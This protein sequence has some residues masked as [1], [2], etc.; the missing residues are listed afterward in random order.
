MP[1]RVALVTTSW[2]AHEQDPA[3]HFVRAEARA[4]ERTG[5]EVVVLAPPAGGAFGWPGVAARIREKPWRALYAARW[6]T[7]ATQRVRNL[8]VD[9][10]V[11]HWALPSAWPIGHGARAPIE[12][13]SHGGDVRLLSALPAS[14]RCHLTRTIAARCAEWRFVSDSLALGL[15]RAVDRPTA[16]LVERVA[17]VRPAP[18]E[19]PDVAATIRRLRR[20]LPGARTAVSVGRLVESKRVD[21][22]IA[23]V[24]TSGE[25]DALV[26]VGDGPERDRLE[27]LARETGA[28][29]VFVGV[30]PRREALGW[31]GAADALLHASAAEGLSTVVREAEAL[32]TRVVRL[33]SWSKRP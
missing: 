8:D 13:V 12:V 25:F 23:H 16:S 18:I 26:V 19:L 17:V 15:L 30:V 28:R 4:I 2:P 11:C 3:G 31:I 14:L 9:R 29:T 5:A 7:V 33:G 21:R 32:G 6:V 20:D 27:R 1:R 10:L 24:A 22:A